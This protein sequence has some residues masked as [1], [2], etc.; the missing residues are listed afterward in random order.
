M[1]NTFKRYAIFAAFSAVVTAVPVEAANS[2]YAP[3]DLILYFQQ[4]GGSNTIYANLG[5]AST[6]Y[7]G[8]TS[9]AAD[10]VNQLNILNLNST[11]TSAFGAGWAS[12]T[13]I[14]SGLAGVFSNAQNSNVVN[15]DPSRTVYVSASRSEVGQVG[16]AAS[17]GYTIPGDTGITAA[18]TRIVQLATQFEINYDSLIAT[19]PTSVSTIDNTNPFSSPGLQGPAFA[20]FAGGVQQQGSTGAFGNFGDAGSTEFALDLYRIVARTGLAGQAADDVLRTGSYEGT[21]TIGTTGEVSFIANAV[22]EPSSFA[23][24]GLAAGALLLR[25]RRRS[26]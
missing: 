24:T 25:R 17:E 21:V 4:E 8:G 26:A 9:G 16:T 2:F 18:A 1:K 3:G 14:Y 20:T 11:L 19:S 23:L 10:G 7:R 22:P 15:G 12:D 5:S 6:L 13:T